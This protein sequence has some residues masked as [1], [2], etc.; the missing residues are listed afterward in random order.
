MAKII[1]L[2][3][4]AALNHVVAEVL[5]K[6][7]ELTDTCLATFQRKL[8]RSTKFISAPGEILVDKI[9]HIARNGSLGKDPFPW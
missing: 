4:L 8:A 5:S 1:L 3:K 7:L 6:F 9:H 2:D